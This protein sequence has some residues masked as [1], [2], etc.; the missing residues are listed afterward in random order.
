[1]NKGFVQSMILGVCAAGVGYWLGQRSPATHTQRTAVATAA[2]ATGS[3]AATASASAG[4]PAAPAA[5]A[6]ETP[7]TGRLP[8]AE[9]KAKLLEL[10][11][12]GAFGLSFEEQRAWLKAMID[13]DPADIPELLDFT[14]RQL[15]R[16]LSSGLQLQLLSHWA[17]REVHKAMAYAKALASREDRELGITIVARAWARQDPKAAADWVRQLPKGRLR[18]QEIG[19]AHV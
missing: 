2:N 8:L 3:T 13:L 16:S 5:D 19:R 11:G 6:A 10:K 12:H 1:M 18:A 9:I 4:H 14:R 15:P 17:D 7:A